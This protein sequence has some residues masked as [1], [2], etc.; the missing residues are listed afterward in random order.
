[1][2]IE[3]EKW[4]SKFGGVRS[5]LKKFFYE[6]EDSGVCH[7]GTGCDRLG[8]AL[9]SAL[10]EVPPHQSD[11]SGRCENRVPFP[12]EVW[13]GQR[14]NAS[15][16]QERGATLFCFVFFNYSTTIIFPGK[17]KGVSSKVFSEPSHI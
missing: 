14:E 9:E 4:F 2:T 3:L 5:P 11:R 7:H 6:K 17:M 12:G 10:T 1:M 15:G 8:R 13:E 16:R